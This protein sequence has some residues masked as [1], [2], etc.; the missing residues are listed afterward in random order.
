M[1]KDVAGLELRVEPQQA[2][3]RNAIDS[4]LEATGVLLDEV[5]YDGLTTKAVA[6]KAGV[7]IATLYRYFPDK[8]SLARALATRYEA[9]YGTRLGAQLEQLAV[10]DDW[11]AGIHA[12]I[13]ETVRVRKLQPGME[14]LRRAL[15]SSTELRM[16]QDEILNGVIRDVGAVLM[17]R[18]PSLPAKDARV[19]ATT[20]V[21]AADA[22]LTLRFHRFTA[23]Q[24]AQQ[25]AEVLIA[26]L[27]PI[28]DAA[29]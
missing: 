27:A 14:G 13:E 17:A 16:L 8:L 7:N 19:Y 2:R 3:A 28:L 21:T 5:G 25:A 12:L 1:H 23:K 18:N 22:V 15:P 4:V 24:A 11:R 26:Y 20:A 9:Q 10:T 29:A 6:A